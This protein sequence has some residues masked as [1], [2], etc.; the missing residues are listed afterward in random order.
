M[1]V[2]GRNNDNAMVEEDGK[3]TTKDHGVG[4]VGHLKFIKAKNVGIARE[5]CGNGRNRVVV[6]GESRLEAMDARV[7]IQHEGVEVDTALA[8]D[9]EAVVEEIHN[10]RLACA[11]VTV[12]VMGLGDGGRIF[13]GFRG[14]AKDFRELKGGRD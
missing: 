2:G 5:I 13:G 11:D 3:E 7:Y 8:G 6:F 1:A 12:D 4:D 9:G 10:H 14:A